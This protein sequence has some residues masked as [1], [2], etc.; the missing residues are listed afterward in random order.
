[1]KKIEMEYKLVPLDQLSDFE[2]MFIGIRCPKTL[3]Y[4]ILNVRGT[5]CINSENPHC[6]EIVTLIKRLEEFEL[7][8]D[9]ALEIFERIAAYTHHEAAMQVS[10]FYSDLCEKRRHEKGR[11]GANIWYNM[12]QERF[13]DDDEEFMQYFNHEFLYELFHAVKKDMDKRP[14]C[15]RNNFPTKRALEA[16]FLY[17]FEAGQESRS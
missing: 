14:N 1:M 10:G 2:R 11:E 12:N 3:K 4:E 5:L 13:T 15:W 8:N 9:E 7:L 6:E 17:G 16:V